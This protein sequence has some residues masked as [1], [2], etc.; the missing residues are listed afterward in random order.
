MDKDRELID[1][2]IEVF[3]SVGIKRLSSML[4]NYIE[5]PDNESLDLIYQE[6]LRW[7]SFASGIKSRNFTFG[8]NFSLLKHFI[9]S[10]SKEY[11]T[12]GDPMIVI[13]KLTDESAS[14]KDNP[15][16]NLKI[17]YQ[18]EEQRDIDYE[19]LLIARH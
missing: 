8:N 5:L 4:K 11:S 9:I 18:N 7:I 16:K 1:I 14:F 3:E 15:I 6:A 10:Q 12:S 13:N 17:I 19:R 2:C